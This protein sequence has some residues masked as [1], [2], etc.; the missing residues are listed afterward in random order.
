MKLRKDISLGP[1]SVAP[2][3]GYQYIDSQ[4]ATTPEGSVA[5]AGLGASL[6]LN[7]AVALTTDFNRRFDF[8]NAKNLQGNIWTVGIRGSF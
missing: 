1:I 3:V 2:I 5:T 6:Q 8:D 7:K 4:S